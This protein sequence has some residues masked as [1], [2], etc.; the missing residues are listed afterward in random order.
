MRLKM[1]REWSWKYKVFHGVIASAPV[2]I[3]A[4]NWIDHSVVDTLP[5]IIYDMTCSDLSYLLRKIHFFHQ[6]STWR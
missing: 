4:V 6:K 3:R 2:C 5:V 1:I